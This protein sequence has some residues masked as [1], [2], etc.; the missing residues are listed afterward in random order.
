MTVWQCISSEVTLKGFKKWCIS[1]A[2]D[3]T[4]DDMW[5]NDSE[6][7]GNVRSECDEDEGT[8]FLIFMGPCITILCQ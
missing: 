3:G 6:E 7:D 8:F 4:D 1:N 5:W 2:M